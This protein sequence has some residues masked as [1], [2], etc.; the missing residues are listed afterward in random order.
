MNTQAALCFV[1]ENFS[2]QVFCSRQDSVNTQAA[3]C[4]VLENFSNPVFRSGC[5]ETRQ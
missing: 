3:L 1:L 4:Y 5:A 2:N